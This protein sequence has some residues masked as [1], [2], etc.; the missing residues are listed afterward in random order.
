MAYHDYNTEKLKQDNILCHSPGGRGRE[1]GGSHWLG[2]DCQR[3]G[4]LQCQGFQG[5]W[6]LAGLMTNRK[7][8]KKKSK[9]WKRNLRCRDFPGKWD[10]AAFIT[11]LI[12]LCFAMVFIQKKFCKNSTSGGII[13][14]KSLD[15][16]KSFFPGCH[17]VFLGF[18]RSFFSQVATS[19][20][21]QF[22]VP[23]HVTDD[24]L[25]AEL[26]RPTLFNSSEKA[27][28][29]TLAC[30][31]LTIIQEVILTSN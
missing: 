10:L 29:W 5:K 18:L 25:V 12:T 2:G 22:A 3:V 13:F 28:T 31:L 4:S 8:I 24:K 26:I 7:R 6:D 23:A 9:E 16:L 20:P 14:C 15:F 11:R 30:A 17:L 21:R 1:G 19:L 27:T